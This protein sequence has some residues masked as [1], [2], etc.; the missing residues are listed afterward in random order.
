MKRNLENLMKIYEEEI[1]VNKQEKEAKE[2]LFSFDYTGNTLEECK[3]QDD[4]FT[5]ISKDIDQQRYYLKIQEGLTKNNIF[6]KFVDLYEEQIR[7]YILEKYANK[8]IGEK[9][10]KEI[11]KYI[12]DILQEKGVFSY[13]HFSKTN[14][15]IFSHKG[16]EIYATFYN[17]EEEKKEYFHGFQINLTLDEWNNGLKNLYNNETITTPIEEIKEKARIL[18]NN[19][20]EAVQKIQEKEKEIDN[21]LKD[22]E[23]DF[24]AV[25]RNFVFDH[26]HINYTKA[27]L[28]E[29]DVERMEKLK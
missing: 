14:E 21:I 22:Y 8:T 3:K 10:E 16:G 15:G 13:I 12:E 24:E 4:E 23:K 28:N 19:K 5:K 18:L 25:A 1:K 26:L 11:S 2:K 20:I 6:K 9:R 27:T 29:Y 17:S 7:P